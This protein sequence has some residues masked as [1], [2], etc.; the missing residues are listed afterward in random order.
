MLISFGISAFAGLTVNLA[1]DAA[2]NALGAAGFVSIPPEFEALF[3]TDVMAAYVNVLLY[4]IIGATFSGMT[5]VFD[6]DRLG[7][8]VQYL[9]Y[10]CATG[11]V[12]AFITVYL[13]QLQRIPA[14]MAGTLAGY[15]LAFLIMGVT[16]YRLV[17]KD[18]DEINEL[19]G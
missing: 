11:A 10:F 7:I 15:G 5:F 16:Q 9:I 19:I 3:P 18:I 2:V 4:G 14:A 17:R 1:I 13:W 12:L 8:L 6:I